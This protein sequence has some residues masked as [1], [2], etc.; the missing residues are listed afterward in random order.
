[1]YGFD[2]SR[3]DLACEFCAYITH[4][5]GVPSGSRWTR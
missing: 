5:A 2:K 3:L 4:P 1:M